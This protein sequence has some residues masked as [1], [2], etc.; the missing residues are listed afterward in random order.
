VTTVYVAGVYEYQAGATTSYYDGGGMRRSGYA[1]GNGV[2]Y[3]LSDHLKSTS[4]IVNQ[5]GVVQT[6]QYHF[7]FGGNR[8]GGFSSL[9]TKRYTGQYH[10][11][12]LPGGEGLYFYNA[13]WYDAQLGRFTQADTIVPDPGNWYAWRL[14]AR[15]AGLE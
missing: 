9:T 4:T 8:S 15:S 2:F 3:T 6:Q 11:A 12:E 5:A 7:P 10:E 14:L 1:S 13:R